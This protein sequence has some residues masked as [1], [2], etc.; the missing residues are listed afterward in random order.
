M[1][2]KLDIVSSLEEILPNDENLLPEFFLK[3]KEDINKDQV[4]LAK[5]NDNNEITWCRA[6]VVDFIDDNEVITTKLF[7]SGKVIIVI[8]C[9]IFK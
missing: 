5:Y 3:H 1:Q 4:Y 6:K 8:I 9:I 2:L 7:S